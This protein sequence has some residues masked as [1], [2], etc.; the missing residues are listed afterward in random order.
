MPLTQR[1]RV[2]VMNWADTYFQFTGEWS[3]VINLS[4]CSSINYR[5]WRLLKYL[6]R[7]CIQPCRINQ[8]YKAGSLTSTKTNRAAQHWD[9][10]PVGPEA[11]WPFN[12]FNVANIAKSKLASGNLQNDSNGQD[13]TNYEW[14]GRSNGNI[15]LSNTIG[16]AC[17]HKLETF[18]GMNKQFSIIGGIWVWLWRKE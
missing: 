2:E 12:P 10:L 6:S 8:V 14:D 4:L 5:G 11:H 1:S 3:V 17:L 7:C 16:V 15:A 13:S 9:K 18:V